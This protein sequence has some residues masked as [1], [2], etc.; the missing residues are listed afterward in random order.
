MN[1]IASHMK[2]HIDS[3]TAVL[4]LAD[5]SAPGITVDIDY[6]F[7]T[8]STVLPRSLASNTAFMF[9]N[10]PDPSLSNFS[11]GIIPDVLKDARQFYFDNPIAR[12]KDGSRTVD[13]RA[14]E[15]NTLEMLKNLFDWLDSLKPQPMTESVSLY[16]S[17]Q[18]IDDKIADILANKDQAAII[19]ANIDEQTTKLQRPPPVSLSHCYHLVLELYADWRT[20]RGLPPTPRVL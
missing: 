16:D 3:V 7:S 18:I 13:L 20:N 9:T 11:G 6:A 8:L 10:V 15:Q 2:D 14:S 4:V 17:S 1:K 19:Q 5:G 12:L